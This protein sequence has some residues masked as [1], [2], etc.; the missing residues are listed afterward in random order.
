MDKDQSA[1]RTREGIN[2]AGGRLYEKNLVER[3]RIVVTYL[4]AFA[5]TFAEAWADEKRS[6]YALLQPSS[7]QITIALLPDVMQRCDF[8]EGFLYTQETFKRQ[9]KPLSELALLNNW[10]KASVDE[11]LST[12]PKREKF[13]GFLREA[14]RL[15]APPQQV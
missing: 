10:N 13:L 8:Y 6:N 1:T 12:A 2:P 7:L 5:E 4:K 3:K 15:K 14:L 11:P 9:L